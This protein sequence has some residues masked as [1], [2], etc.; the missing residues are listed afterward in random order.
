MCW[1]DSS[2]VGAPTAQAVCFPQTIPD[3]TRSSWHN[4]WLYSHIFSFA[5][6]QDHSKWNLQIVYSFLF[7]FSCGFVFLS[8]I[9]FLHS[10]LPGWQATGLPCV[11]YGKTWRYASEPEQKTKDGTHLRPGTHESIS[12]VRSICFTRLFDLEKCPHTDTCMICMYLKQTKKPKNDEL[13]K[14][15]QQWLVTLEVEGGGQVEA[16]AGQ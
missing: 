4:Q 12:M 8:F 16:S 5:N 6:S 11:Q 9:F 14:K 15:S 2:A 3:L 10:I 7:V 13:K 1:H